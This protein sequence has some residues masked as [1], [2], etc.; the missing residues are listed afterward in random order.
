MYF[1]KHINALQIICFTLAIIII[2]YISSNKQI[3][4][5]FYENFENDTNLTINKKFISKNNN[6]L[7]D[8]FYVN[9][10]DDLFFNK[11]KNDFEIVN[12]IKK[13][14]MNNTSY[15][16][17]IGSGTGH[18]VSSLHAHKLK[19]IGIDKSNSMIVKSKNMY[20][21][22][23]FKKGDALNS[24]LFFE[25]TFT[26]I[27]ALYFTI[28]YI[29]DKKSF[30]NNCFKWLMPGGFLSIHLV[31]RAKFNPIVPA[32]DLF[33]H[34]SMQDYSDERI[35]KSIVQFIDDN[36]Y[37]AKFDYL[38]NDD[39]SIFKETF[40]SKNNNV[41]NQEHTLYMPT[42]EFILNIAKSC[43]FKIIKKLDMKDIKYNYQY[44][45]ILQKPN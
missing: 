21:A 39:L 43:G 17:D 32:S 10:Y 25:N 22:L 9:Y 28:Y 6:N 8:D 44:I 23:N 42:H 15:V 24:M 19:A 40:K 37:R 27:I 13:T 11:A 30:F 12:L 41:R 26:H 29:K 33:Y 1:F 16:L 2:F 14:N 3:Y 38:P 20:P 45:Y 36:S 34:A 18:H 35:T 4:N 5:N 7:Y 31:D